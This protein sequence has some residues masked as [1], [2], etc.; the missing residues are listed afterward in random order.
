VRHAQLAGHT[1]ILGAQAGL[2]P[3][4]DPE[5]F[6]PFLEDESTSF[7]LLPLLP[8]LQTHNGVYPIY[9]SE[10]SSGQARR[11]GYKDSDQGIVHGRTCLTFSMASDN[12]QPTTIM[13]AST[14]TTFNQDRTELL[15]NHHRLGHVSIKRA[16]SLNTDGIPQLPSKMP[17]KKYP[18]CIA[19]KATQHKRISTTT[20]DTTSASGSWQDI[21]RISQA[22]CASHP[23]ADIDTSP[24]SYAHG[25]VPNIANL[26]HAR[27][28]S[29]THIVDSWQLQPSCHNTS[30]RF[31]HMKE[32][33]I[34][35]I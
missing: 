14:S 11:I 25:Q 35:T 1:V 15:N 31:E 20:A 34:S 5:L 2:L 9:N 24:F 4:G 19:S 3:Y 33:N 18:V 29:S 27:I 23:Y 13:R 16:R 10:P 28:T 21:Y 17:K 6:I 30:A 7:W 8:P 22:K 26:L 12:G 32:E